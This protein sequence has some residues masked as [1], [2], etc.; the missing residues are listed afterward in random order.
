[1]DRYQAGP[2][3]DWPFLQS[4]LYL[5]LWISF[6]Q[7][8]FGIDSFVGGLFSL[9]SHGVVCLST[10]GVL[11]I[12][13]FYLFNNITTKQHTISSNNLFVYFWDCN[14]I[15]FLS[16]LSFSKSSHIPLPGLLQIHDPCPPINFVC[17][18]K[19]VNTYIL[20]YKL[21]SSYNIT[22][23]ESDIIISF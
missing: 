19:F 3:I 13:I 8:Q 12:C 22:W 10:G 2:V 9:S 23:C 7:E 16:S 15:S 20:M 5:C 6:I 17:I 18:N 14:F 21:F 11:C 1:M 4:L